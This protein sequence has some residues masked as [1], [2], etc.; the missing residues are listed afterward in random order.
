MSGYNSIENV[1]SSQA[2]AI[3]GLFGI[4]LIL[5]TFLTINIALLIISRHSCKRILSGLVLIS[6][7]A[8]IFGS[9][10]DGKSQGLLIV[11]SIILPSIIIGM[12]YFLTNSRFRSFKRRVFL[13]SIAALISII[14]LFGFIG[15]IRTGGRIEGGSIMQIFN[16]LQFP[17]INMEWQLQEF[18][19]VDGAGNIFPL[20]AGLIPYRLI[21]GSEYGLYNTYAIFSFFYPEP[22]IGAG[23]FGP[24]H[25]AFGI[26]GVIVFG[27]LT[28]LISRKI[29]NLARFDP[30]WSVPYSCFVWPLI[31]AHSYSHLTS[32]LFFLIPFFFSIIISH[33]V[34]FSRPLK[35]PPYLPQMCYHM[36][37]GSL[38][39]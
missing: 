6:L 23:Y 20:L 24:A 33:F 4:W 21:S 31:S 15:Y 14:L 2:A 10:M 13:L 27:F 36:H 37:N 8:V 16:Y 28:G 5:N 32:A 3:P 12:S 34:F 7:V 18:G 29:F 19:L 30:R 22:G 9:I 25:L 38:Q 1:N 39:I 17:L 11:A 35:N 26:V